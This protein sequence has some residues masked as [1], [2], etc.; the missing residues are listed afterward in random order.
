MGSCCPSDRKEYNASNIRL[1][2][3]PLSSHKSDKRFLF[4]NSSGTGLQMEPTQADCPRNHLVRFLFL[5]GNNFHKKQVLQCRKVKRCLIFLSALRYLSPVIC[6]ITPTD[7]GFMLVFG[8][9]VQA[10]NFFPTSWAVVH[11]CEKSFADLIVT[12]FFSPTI[13]SRNS[14][15]FDFPVLLWPTKK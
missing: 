14:K 15:N 13:S 10:H 12:Q 1:V 4:W 11:L 3:Y 5:K 8:K 9:S 2:A 6:F 7:S